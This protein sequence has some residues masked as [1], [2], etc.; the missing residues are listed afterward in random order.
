MV[1]LNISRLIWLLK[2]SIKNMKMN[3]MKYSVLIVKRGIDLDSLLLAD[4]SFFLL[5]SLSG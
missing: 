4:K 2:V 3:M 1:A 5:V